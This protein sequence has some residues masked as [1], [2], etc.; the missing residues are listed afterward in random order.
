MPS[1]SEYPPRWRQL[2]TAERSV[3][4]TTFRFTPMPTNAVT[5]TGACIPITFLLQF[6]YNCAVGNVMCLL[7]IP[8]CITGDSG[9]NP[10]QLC[11]AYLHTVSRDCDNCGS[12]SLI[13]P[14]PRR[15]AMGS[16]SPLGA[17]AA[18]ET[19]LNDYAAVRYTNS[20]SINLSNGMPSESLSQ[21]HFW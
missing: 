21:L 6:V 15:S 5:F 4:D 9:I 1:V 7:F 19:A 12:L 20:D 10:V 11:L 17:I 3:L 13:L 18:E 16:T 8:I 14:P 2:P